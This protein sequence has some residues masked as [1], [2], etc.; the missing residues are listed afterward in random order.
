MPQAAQ[1]GGAVA[2][3]LPLQ[4]LARRLIRFARDG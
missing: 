3:V 2:E 1:A 4:A